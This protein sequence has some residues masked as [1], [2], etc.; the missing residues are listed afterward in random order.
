MQ[1]MCCHLRARKA[2]RQSLVPKD[3][4]SPLHS[5]LHEYQ[6][7]PR[8]HRVANP[9]IIIFT[10]LIAS[11][12]ARR[13]SLNIDSGAFSNCELLPVLESMVSSNKT[14]LLFRRRTENVIKAHLPSIVISDSAHLLTL[15]GF[16]S[17]AMSD[18]DLR[19]TPSAHD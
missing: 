12:S 15:T 10:R 8:L 18:P 1:Q 5:M 13:L 17:S 19:S 11:R 2:A 3:N 7:L 16:H 4:P 14:K 9:T 6:V